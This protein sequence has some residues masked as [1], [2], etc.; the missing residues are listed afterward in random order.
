VNYTVCSFATDGDSAMLVVLPQTVVLLRYD[1]TNADAPSGVTTVLNNIIG[2]DVS[3]VGV[4]KITDT[5][6][7]FV[8]DEQI[9][10]KKLNS[11]AVDQ[12]NWET[13][14]KLADEV[15][16]TCAFA[17]S[18]STCVGVLGG[19]AGLFLTHWWP[20]QTLLARFKRGMNI[21]AVDIQRCGTK[22]V[23]AFTEGRVVH[24]VDFTVL[25]DLDKRPVDHLIVPGSGPLLAVFVQVGSDDSFEGVKVADA[26]GTQFLPWYELEP[27]TVFKAVHKAVNGV[28]DSLTEFQRALA[29][30]EAAIYDTQAARGGASAHELV[31]YG[32]VKARA[33]HEPQSSAL[34]LDLLRW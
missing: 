10:Y 12:R 25:T 17:A 27:L 32:T 16:R 22:F 33:H 11:G 5:Y 6:C 15:F 23:L 29:Q 13:A 21:G 9:R 8:V 1:P 26:G 7:A 24:V 28:S 3:A 20:Q 18:K 30:Q 34:L 14:S 19:N 4:H 2:T 31:A